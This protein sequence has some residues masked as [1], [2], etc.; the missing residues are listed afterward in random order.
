[1]AAADPRQPNP[2]GMWL[3]RCT[4]RSGS[5]PPCCRAHSM[6]AAAVWLG[7]SRYTGL[8][9]SATRA[10]AAVLAA[11]LQP[12]W[13]RSCS[14]WHTFVVS[15]RL[16]YCLQK[17]CRCPMCWSVGTAS[18]VLVFASGGYSCRTC[19]ATVSAL[20]SCTPSSTAVGTGSACCC[21]VPHRCWCCQRLHR[22]SCRAGRACLQR[23]CWPAGW[24]C[25]G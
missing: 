25:Q 7:G 10:A 23:P 2:G 6:S 17:N 3:L 5:A 21:A 20:G 8:E 16:F 12:T 15:A 13:R 24:T 4:P 9:L 1:M 18:V 11:K 22:R 14:R 19:A